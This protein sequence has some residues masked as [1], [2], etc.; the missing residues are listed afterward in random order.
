MKNWTWLLI[1]GLLALGV[2][3]ILKNYFAA[4][5]DLPDF[6]TGLG[7]AL[8]LGSL[9]VAYRNGELKRPID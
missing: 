3:Y 9:W 5:D 4:G 1:T 8:I 7:T 6:I 2:T